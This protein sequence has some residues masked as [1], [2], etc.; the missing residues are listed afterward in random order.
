MSTNTIAA[1]AT[2]LSNSGISIVRISGK[3]S[4]NVIN[5]I[6]SLEVWIQ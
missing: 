5:K 6:N 1:I 2:A 4:L 3:D